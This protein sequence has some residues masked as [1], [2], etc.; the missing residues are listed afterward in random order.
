MPWG[1]AEEWFWQKQPPFCLEWVHTTDWS[2]ETCRTWLQ[3]DPAQQ[4]PP[5]TNKQRTC[6]MVTALKI[7]C[8][9][10]RSNHK[11]RYCIAGNFRWVKFSLSGL[12]SVFS[13]SYFRCMSWTRYHSSLLS[14]FSWVNFSFWGSLY[15]KNKNKTQRK[16]PATCTCIRY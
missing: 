12:E 9:P 13:W 7:T 1:E 3:S 11:N 5:P 16:F 14:K 2:V 6:I 4:T 10:C 8:S 15:K